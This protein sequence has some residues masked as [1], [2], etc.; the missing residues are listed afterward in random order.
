MAGRDHNAA[1]KVIHTGN[2]GHGRGS[3]DMEQVSICTGS[4]QD[5]DQ[6]VLEHIGATTSVLAND[7][8]CRLVVA[9]ALTQSVLVPA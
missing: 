7:D 8:A 1:I 6:A 4:G 2:I 5:C 3:S 9:V